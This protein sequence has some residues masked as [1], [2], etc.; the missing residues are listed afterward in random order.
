MGTFLR[1]ALIR[2]WVLNKL[3]VIT[4]SNRIVLF[5][6]KTILCFHS[7][8]QYLCKVIGTKESVYIRKEFN[9]H[10]T[11]LGHKYGRHDIM[12]KHTIDNKMWR[13]TKVEFQLLT[14]SFF[15]ILKKAW[16]VGNS[17]SSI[18]S[19]I[20]ISFFSKVSFSWWGWVP[21]IWGWILNRING[22][23]KHE[24][25]HVGEI[26]LPPRRRCQSIAG[27]PHTILLVCIYTLGWREIKRAK[28]FV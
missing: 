28:F 3:F 6:N 16:S 25:Y 12:W 1:W 24:K 26:L 9:S 14:E 15:K 20:S 7:Y 10:R 17:F 23:S 18:M 27:Y 19:I 8:G 22:N 11:G 2:G 5:C 13:C 4:F 21:G